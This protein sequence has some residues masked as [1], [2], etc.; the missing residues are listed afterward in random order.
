MRDDPLTVLGATDR[1]LLRAAR[2]GFVAPM[3]AT[4][5]DDRFSDPDWIFERKFDGERVVV[6]RDGGR[7]ELFTRNNKSATATFPELV[8]ALGAQSSDGLVADGEVV[9]FDGKTT[10]FS[11]LQQ[12]LGVTDPQ[13]A[14]GSDVAVTIYLFDAMAVGGHDLTP[15]PL[16]SR[17][18]VLNAAVDARDPV[19][20][21]AHR[22]T[23]GEDYLRDACRRGWEGLIAKR[24]DASYRPGHR[25]RD[26]LKFKCVRDQELVVGGF[27]D[28]TGSRVGLGALLV[29]YHDRGRL[30]YAGKVGTG[31]DE[32]QLRSLRGRLDEMTVPESPFAERVRESTATWVRPELVAQIGFTEWTRDG[33]LRHPRFL[34]LRDD[35]PAPDVVREEAV[36]R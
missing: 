21:S 10:S 14:R 25:S 31:L 5:T 12:R 24:A 8:D 34:G 1:D 4:L 9:A 22:N 30:R 33:R 13:R 3:L 2:P 29:G 17:K 35:K 19:R 27:T 23:D 11:R 20:I 6:V 16:R 26:W 32:N 36:P 18:R 15:L 28:P 7:T